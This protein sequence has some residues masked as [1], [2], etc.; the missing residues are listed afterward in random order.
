[1]VGKLS[2]AW[3]NAI[4]LVANASI[5]R[6][7]ALVVNRVWRDGKWVYEGVRLVNLATEDDGL[8]AAPSA[9]ESK[10]DGQ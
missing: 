6:D 10:D 8:A 9:L 4:R 5:P 1:M 3:L 7:E 2:P